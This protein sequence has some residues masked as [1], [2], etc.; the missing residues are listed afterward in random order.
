MGPKVADC[1]LLFGLLKYESFP[2]DVW[3]KRIM[4]RLYGFELRDTKGM[5]EHAARH[6]GNLSGFAQQYLFYYARENL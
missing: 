6:F 1:V 4:S 2:L 3:M 5:S